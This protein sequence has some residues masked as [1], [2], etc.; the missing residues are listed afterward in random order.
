MQEKKKGAMYTPIYSDVSLNKDMTQSQYDLR[1]ILTQDDFVA[2]EFQ[3]S[4]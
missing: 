2:H 1:T 3:P 4:P